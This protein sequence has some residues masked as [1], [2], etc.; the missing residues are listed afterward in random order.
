MAELAAPP[1]MADGT[2]IPAANISVPV[3]VTS[4]APSAPAAPQEP[5]FISETLYI[6]N[7]NEKIKI[8]GTGILSSYILLCDRNFT[9][10]IS[11]FSA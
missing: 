9:N 3:P 7:L 5:E 11:I 4:A 8:P 6:Q 1:V 2:Q 10:N